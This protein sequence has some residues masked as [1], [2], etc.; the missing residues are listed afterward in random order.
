MDERDR[1][2]LTVERPLAAASTGELVREMLT[3]ASDLVKKEVELAKT[4]IRADVKQQIGAAKGLGIAAVCALTTL[5]LVLVAI[6]LALEIEGW[7]AVLIV[8][9]VVAVIGAVAG[10]I[11]WSR[12][13]RTPLERTQKTVKEDVKWAKEKLA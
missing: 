10:L 9:A 5:N 13:V 8:A 1:D 3:Q 6:A 11:G 4:E 2:A 12:R 7:L